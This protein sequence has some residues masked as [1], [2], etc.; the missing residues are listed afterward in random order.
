[1]E[2]I[3]KTFPGVLANDQI[4]FDV[5]EGEIHAL[6]GE[7][8]AG[9]TTLMRI[10][11]G[12][13]S[14]D[15]G[16]ICWR[17]EPVEISS[18]HDA[19]KL[20]VGMVHQHFMLIPEFTVVENVVLGLRT[21]RS[22]L[23]DLEE[24]AE[25][26]KQLSDQFGLY[27][28]PWVLVKDLSTGEQQRVEIV[29]TLYRGAHLLA[30]DEPTAVLT[31]GEIDE[32]FTILDNLRSQGHALVFISH[33]LDEVMR[34]SDRVTVLRDGRVVATVQ[35]CDTSK[36]DLATMMVGRPVVL[37]VDRRPHEPGEEVIRVDDVTILTEDHRHE[38]Y[39]AS[40]SVRQ[41]E[42]VSIMGVAGNGQRSLVE[43]L[44]GLRKLTSGYMSI[45][46]RD[47]S[48]CKPK[49]L[50]LLN[51]GRIPEDRH[52]MGLALTLS[53]CENLVLETFGHSSYSSMGVLKQQEINSLALRL[54][55]EYDI[56]MPT[57]HVP[58]GTLSGGNQQ[59]VILA[60]AMH[61][62]PPALIA[63]DPTRGLDIG[64]TE[65]V[66]GQLL[67]ARDRGVAVLLISTDM[68]EALCLSDRIAVIYNG[69]IMGTVTTE[70]TT[71][72]QLG[73][74]MAGTH[75]EALT[76]TQNPRASYTECSSHP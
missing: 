16:E 57:V 6:L 14:P 17:G 36:E 75:L 22:P 42:I 31:P 74:M 72:T 25:R 48:E 70:E 62:N 3:T 10:L 71:E 61:R 68:E 52:T 69:K 15:S 55:D 7:N 23:L 76:E 18:S 65:F 9:K 40:F 44:F 64:A 49:D 56:R 27:V 11:Y 12:M 47:V 54:G 37:R 5:E 38:V 28:D 73:L 30:L 33:K 24:A 45:M 4:T 39:N 13:S 58:A 34:I 43:T 1:M 20:G 59:K 41:G 32:F 19:I 63:V 60:R 35:T 29:K 26:L 66:Y 8:G 51:V 50:V 53:V 21:A 2:G 46:E 67:K